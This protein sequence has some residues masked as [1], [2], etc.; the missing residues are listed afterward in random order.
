MDKWTKLSEEKVY[1]GY[2]KVFRKKFK[3]PDGTTVDY[4]TV[5]TGAVVCT[6]A[7][8]S[9]QKIILVRQFRP[10]PEY[11][12][13]DLP[14]G[15]LDEGEEPVQGAAREL[16]EETGYQGTM[17]LVV[18]TPTDAY[19]GAIR[20]HF[21]AEGCHFVQD[22]IVEADA[23][24]TEVVLM[25]LP[26]FRQHIQDGQLVDIATGYLGLDYLKLL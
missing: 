22:P 5:G 1:N 25:T 19:S 13:V 7:L 9:D 3:L 24:P 15:G 18:S 6:L 14:G 12:C 17:S 20:H 16:L 2:R 23:A 26:E 4:D 21:V 8:T 10:G 11:F